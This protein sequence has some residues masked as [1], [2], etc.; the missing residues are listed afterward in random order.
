MQT[1]LGSG[2]L[3]EV[4]VV[5]AVGREVQALWSWVWT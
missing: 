5:A 2:S 1:L 3:A 4:E